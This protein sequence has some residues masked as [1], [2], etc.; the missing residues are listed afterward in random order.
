M[1]QVKIITK[2]FTDDQGK[3]VQYERLAIIGYV[4]G[5]IHTLELKLNSSET[6]LAKMLL[7]SN[8]EKPT[9]VTTKGGQVEVTKTTKTILDDDDEGKSSLFDD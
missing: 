3:V 4:S 1:A 9:V 2:E 5:E 6:L 7:S 8:E